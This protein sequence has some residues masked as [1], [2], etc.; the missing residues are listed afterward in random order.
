MTIAYQHEPVLAEAAAAFLKPAD[1]KVF[2]D[3]TLGGGGHA[4][5]IKDQRSKIKII[6]FDRDADALAAAR[7]NLAGFSDIEY[8]HDNFARLKEHVKEKV[9]GI[10]FDLG[11]SSYQ[12]DEGGRGFSL[13]HDGPLDMRMDRRGKLTA[14]EIVNNWPAE[15]LTKLFYE[16]GEEKFSRRISKAIVATRDSRPVTSTFELKGIVEKAIPTWKK[17]ESVTRVFQ[18]L[19]IAVNDELNSLKL[20]L[21]QALGLLKPGGRLVVISYHSLE[22][23]AV[24]R[25]FRS[26]AQN[27]ILKPLTKKPVTAGVAE[28]AG[29]PRARSAKLRAAEKL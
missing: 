8:V 29:N 9:D 25:L 18:A 4:S 21:G 19:R 2:V 24:K 22:D 16:C 26:A 5:K 10:L 3:A 15:E 27:G 17:R 20:A 7:K 12:L 6:G 13:Q 23:R 11:V 1:G 14:A 28:L